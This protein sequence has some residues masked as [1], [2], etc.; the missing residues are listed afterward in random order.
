MY[1]N[2]DVKRFEKY[3]FSYGTSQIPLQKNYTTLLIQCEQNLWRNL[4]L[5]QLNSTS[6]DSKDFSHN[7]I[8]L[9]V[10]SK[11]I[12][13]ENSLANG[14]RVLKNW[15]LKWNVLQDK[16]STYCFHV[17]CNI[18][19]IKSWEITKTLKLQVESVS[20]WIVLK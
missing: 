11:K 4:K 7:N 14:L 13:Q 8:L 3:S 1:L 15:R 17:K 6:E 9:H 5:M 16:T 2:F 20:I 18:F 12:T 19:K 10:I